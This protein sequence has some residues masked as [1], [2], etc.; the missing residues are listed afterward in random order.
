MSEVSWPND[1]LSK[2]QIQKCSLTCVLVHIMIS[3]RT[4]SMYWFK[5]WKIEYLK[6]G[7]WHFYDIKKLL[8]LSFK[9]S[10][11]RER[12]PNT[13]LFLVRIF[14]YLNLRIQSEYRKIRTRNNSVLGHFSRSA[15]SRRGSL[16]TKFKIKFK[17][18]FIK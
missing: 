9:L 13:E 16:K 6:N 8:K 1:L 17:L 4:K 2:R 10:S 14:Q 5:I 7:T 15:F 12:C 18:S 11:L 3:Q